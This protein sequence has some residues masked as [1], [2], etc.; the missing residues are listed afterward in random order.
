MSNLLFERI[1]TFPVFG[2]FAQDKG[3]RH[4]LQRR[5][6]QFTIGDRYDLNVIGFSLAAAGRHVL[7]RT[8]PIM[9]A[10]L[11]ALPTLPGSV[12]GGCRLQVDRDNL[13]MVDDQLIVDP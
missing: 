13:A 9:G 3:F 5:Y 8:L 4:A 1:R 7:R 12:L 2:P 10:G 11:L 6:A